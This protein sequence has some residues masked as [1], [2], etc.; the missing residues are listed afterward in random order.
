MSTLTAG[1]CALAAVASLAGHVFG[2]DLTGDRMPT[3]PW[4][5]GLCGALAGVG[6]SLWVGRR[7]ARLAQVVAGVSAVGAMLAS[8]LILIPHNLLYAIVWAAQLVNPGHN[9][10]DR[11]PGAEIVPRM[12]GHLLAVVASAALAYATLRVWRTMRG[13]CFA[14]GRTAA[15]PKPVR[16]RW[17]V[18][19]GLLSIVGC[20][21]YGLLKIAWSLGSRIGMT[22][23]QFDGIGFDSPGFGDT[24]VLT[25]VS[26][27][28]SA[29]MLLGLA[30]RWL[31]PVLA[32][33]GAVGSV[34]LLPVGVLGAARTFAERVG[35]VSS[36]VTE[37]APWVFHTVY[38]SFFA[39]GIGLCGLTIAY[40]RR[41][42]RRCEA[43]SHG[44][45]D[46]SAGQNR[47]SS[48]SMVR[49]SGS[50]SPTTL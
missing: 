21:P 4:W 13:R 45:R 25:S 16:T 43:D 46:Q 17:L 30:G 15:E 23:H 28:A 47:S 34:M 3:A 49:S 7:P 22:G 36:D 18:G 10:F 33:V 38:V 27:V 48:A 41:T 31:R 11:V 35:L 20:L 2:E 37:L 32:F 26:I 29:S 44:V 14:C 39:W 42:A 1:L 19:F 9:A 50:E 24:A 6:W 12:V 8:S 5:F 40:V